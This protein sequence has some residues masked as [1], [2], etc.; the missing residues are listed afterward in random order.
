MTTRPKPSEQHPTAELRDWRYMPD[1]T[2]VYGQFFN[3]VIW[4]DGAY[5]TV[6]NI[7][8]THRYKDHA[9]FITEGGDYYKAFYNTKHLNGG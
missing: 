8:T 9:F 3:H 1:V 5:G 2:M 4:E 6:I 7:V